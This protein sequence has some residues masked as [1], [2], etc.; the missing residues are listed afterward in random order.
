MGTCWR[1]SGCAGPRGARRMSVRDQRRARRSAP[2]VRIRTASATMA[3]SGS[4]G[5]GDGPPPG[6]GVGSGVGDG[7]GPLPQLPTMFTELLSSVTAPVRAKRPPEFVAPVF[8]VMLA[9]ARTLPA[10]DVVVPRV[11][12]LPT[13]QNAPQAWPPLM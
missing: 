12:E 4:A 5:T 3:M 8:N 1:R 10:N 6:V 9:R 7:A 13:C 2:P 11:A